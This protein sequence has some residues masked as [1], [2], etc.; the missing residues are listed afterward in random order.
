MKSLA[1]MSSIRY[2]TLPRRGLG[3]TAKQRMLWGFAVLK[4]CWYGCL[5]LTYKSGKKY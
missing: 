5:V 2:S 4:M 3:L 1:S